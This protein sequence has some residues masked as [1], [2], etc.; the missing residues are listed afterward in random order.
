MAK[1]HIDSL[2]GVRGVAALWVALLHGSRYVPIEPV[3]GRAVTNWVTS[4]WLGV[5]LFF[6]LSGFVIAYVHQTDF[7]RW[8]AARYWRFLKLRLSRLYPAHLVATLVL[9]PIVLSATSLS[10]YQFTPETRAEYTWPK[11]FFSLSLLNGWGFPDSIGW[12]V[13]SWSVGSEWFA[14]LLFPVLALAVNRVRSPLAHGALIL[15]VFAAMIG[16]SIW[17][18]DGQTYMPGQSLTLLRVGSGFLIGCSI[19]NIHRCL[20]AGPAFDAL[21]LGATAAIVV[22]GAAGLPH[23]YD[24]L[25]VAAFAAL[26][27]GLS[28]ARGPA[29]TLF[30]SAPAVYLGRISYSIYL[31]HLTVLMVV[32]Q[33]LQRVLPSDLGASAHLTIFALVYFA[34]FLTAGHLLYTWV[35]EPA[36]TYL[37]RNWV[38]RERGHA[39]SARA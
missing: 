16:I 9:V 1:Q 28:L 39:V 2:T 25:M 3:L 33:G 21:A 23:F 11:L 32:N 7:P 37:R 10:L 14:Y 38:N 19:Y 18:R 35:E 22:L 34:G 26:I 24:F 31:I 30:S 29:A 12:N 20:R 4:G 27:L 17:V 13:P 5:D 8:D 36:R 15:A 6:V